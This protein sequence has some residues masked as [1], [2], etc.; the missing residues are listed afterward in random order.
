MNL[1]F[2]LLGLFFILFFSYANAGYIDMNA[3]FLEDLNGIVFLNIF[4]KE[5]NN[6]VD[7]NI[8]QVD[9]DHVIF[10][11]GDFI[12][13]RVG[14]Y[15]L[16]LNP[17]DIKDYNKM[18]IFI[19]TDE[20]TLLREYDLNIIK[21]EKIKI[22]VKELPLEQSQADS[23]IIWLNKEVFIFNLSGKEIIILNSYIVFFI[24]LMTIGVFVKRN[25]F[26]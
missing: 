25:K 1:K 10:S 18:A 6:S 21:S 16:Q 17:V 2:V 15:S 12:Q 23:I 22:I 4:I 9:F 5:N 24:I 13:S 20:N 11:K 26:K 14:E 7:V 8:L 3:S 19:I